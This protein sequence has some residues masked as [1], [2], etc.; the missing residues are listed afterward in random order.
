[1]GPEDS[2][3]VLRI[4]F[5]SNLNMSELQQTQDA[6]PQGNGGVADAMNKA[7]TDSGAGSADA[8]SQADLS[9]FERATGRKFTS[10]EDAEKYLRNLNS[11][12]GDGRIAEQRKKAELADSVIQQYAS[13]RQLTYAE[14]EAELRN[15]V[16]PSRKS[17]PV[18]APEAVRDPRIDQMEEELFL[19][20][21]PE[22]APHLEKIRRYAKAGSLSLK[23]A[24]NDLYGEV[25]SQ[26]AK[27][28]QSEAKRK[29]KQLASIPT[30][31]S[32]A[33]VGA[34]PQSKILL[35]Q[36]KKTGK[37]ELMREAIKAR[38]KETY[39]QETEE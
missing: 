4:L 30:S 32:A 26:K 11:M 17:Q 31:Q 39:V 6:D 14:A 18:S 24:Y 10:V 15:I 27:E 19:T 21:T 2:Q 3:R 23:E 29:E 1:M 5:F 7:T 12:V 38:K 33:P 20:K 22:A 28:A 35:E 34:T 36:Y 37:P 8:S 25:L 13:E 16:A 9:F